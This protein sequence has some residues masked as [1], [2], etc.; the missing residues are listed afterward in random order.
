M[1]D[2]DLPPNL[3]RL[4]AQDEKQILSHQ[5]VTKAVNLG[6]EEERRKKKGEN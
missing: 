5:E 1:K 2:D 6:I 4:V 3:L